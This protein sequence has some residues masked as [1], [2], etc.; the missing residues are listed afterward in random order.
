MLRRVLCAMRRGY[1][2]LARYLA[3][4]VDAWLRGA[5][6]PCTCPG[7]PACLGSIQQSPWH[8]V[9]QGLWTLRPCSPHPGRPALGP[10]L[11]TSARRPS[12]QSVQA[13]PS[14]CTSPPSPAGTADVKRL[15]RLR[16]LQ[17]LVMGNLQPEVILQGKPASAPL[18]LR[19]CRHLAMLLPA[20]AV[21]ALLPCVLLSCARCSHLSAWR[22]PAGRFVSVQSPSPVYA[23]QRSR[24]QSPISYKIC[25][26]TMASRICSQP[27]PTGCPMHAGPARHDF[28]WLQRCL[29]QGSGARLTSNELAYLLHSKEVFEIPPLLPGSGSSSSGGSSDG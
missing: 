28:S 26:A 7:F 22:K 2:L 20:V 18:A 4:C 12:P 17:T 9:L 11:C 24:A 25:C 19:S 13:S 10:S 6:G 29:R 23:W 8:E 3:P 21:D 27:V 15:L 14:L 1:T 5:H 16:H